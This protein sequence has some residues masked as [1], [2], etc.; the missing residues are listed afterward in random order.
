LKVLGTE[1]LDRANKA[2]GDLRSSIATWLSIAREAKWTSLNGVRLT[3]HSTDCVKGK[4]IFNIKGMGTGDPPVQ[5]LTCLPPHPSNLLPILPHHSIHRHRHIPMPL[6]IPKLHHLMPIP[7]QLPP[8]ARLLRILLNRFLIA[9]VN[10][11]SQ[12]IV[13]KM[14]LTHAEYSQGG[15]D[16]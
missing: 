2:H 14:L 11:A 9:T 13:V 5:V 4:T 15:W 10:Y 3:W 8:P 7:R 1:V 16:S 6:H 12:T